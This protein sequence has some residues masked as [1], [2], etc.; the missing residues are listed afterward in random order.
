MLPLDDRRVRAADLILM[1]F[2]VPVIVAEHQPAEFARGECGLL[3]FVWL[4]ELLAGESMLEVVQVDRI[5]AVE[6]DCFA[7]RAVPGRSVTGPMSA[8]L[9][10]VNASYLDDVANA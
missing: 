6:D 1:P 4:R 10:L 3:A 7:I 5:L 2:V 8:P 9:L